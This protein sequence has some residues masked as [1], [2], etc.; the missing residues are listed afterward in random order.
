MSVMDKFKAIC[1]SYRREQ[2]R[3]YPD[4]KDYFPTYPVIIDGKKYLID[5]NDFVYNNYTIVGRKIREQ[6]PQIYEWF[7]KGLPCP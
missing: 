6:I 2:L 7:P 3:L 4:L 1:L 5:D